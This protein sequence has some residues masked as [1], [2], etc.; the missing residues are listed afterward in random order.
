MMRRGWLPGPF[1]D[2]TI[3]DNYNGKQNTNTDI[4]EP[5]DNPITDTINEAWY[6]DPLQYYTDFQAV[7]KKGHLPN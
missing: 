4:P 7:L 2:E 6:S 1:Y 3:P 5:I